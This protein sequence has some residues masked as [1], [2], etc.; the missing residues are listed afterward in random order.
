MTMAL[1]AYLKIKGD[2]HGEIKGS[3][4]QQGRENSIV[5]IATS[6]EIV[7]PRD[8]AN[9]QPTGK[10]Q[11]KPFV[12]TKEVDRAS[13]VL[14]AMLTTNEK[15]KSW[16]LEYWQPSATGKEVQH[17]TVELVG[18][19]IA[20]IRQEMLNNKYPENMQHKEREH[21]S[22]CY[23]KISWTWTDGGITH[24]DSW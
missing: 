4:T 23:D 12:I 5:V 14:Y 21:I 3:A 18:A 1:N 13:P 11:H 24:Q 10:Q 19:N 16:R 15:C 7:A 22:F 8:A 9:G 17:F 20:G 2:K 6:H